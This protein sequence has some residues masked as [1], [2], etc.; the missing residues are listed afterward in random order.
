MGIRKGCGDSSVGDGCP[1]HQERA[2][3]SSGPAAPALGVNAT[4]CGNTG[5]RSQGGGPGAGGLPLPLGSPH[6]ASWDH[7]ST[8]QRADSSPSPRGDLQV[9]TGAGGFSPEKCARSLDTHASPVRQMH[10][11]YRRRGG[12]YP[13]KLL[14]PSPPRPGPQDV[15]EVPDT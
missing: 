1:A 6:W 11:G 14:G 15:T 3:F 8:G 4:V 13:P 7:P 9:D 2:S 5:F 10:R 12:L